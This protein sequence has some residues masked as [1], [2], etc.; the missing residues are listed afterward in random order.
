MTRQSHDMASMQPPAGLCPSIAATVA[1]RLVESLSH[2]SCRARQK[3]RSRSG[4][5]SC[6]SV[7]SRPA[8]KTLGDDEASTTARHALS[9]SASARESANDART[10]RLREL[11][12]GRCRRRTRVAGASTSS[13]SSTVR[14]GAVD[15][16]RS[17]P[18]SGAA[19]R[20]DARH[21]SGA[22]ERRDARHRSA[23]IL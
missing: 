17:R 12:G 14:G 19:L 11:T 21:R 1:T 9:L 7:M 5:G 4:S 23:A 8:E 16:W 13:G 10:S 15:S 20:R 3:V 22:A 6:I 18:R 2:T